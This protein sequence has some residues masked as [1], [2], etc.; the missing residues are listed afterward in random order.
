[1][2]DEKEDGEMATEDDRPGV[3]LERM[4]L[5]LKSQ[6]LSAAGIDFLK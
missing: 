1:M 2:D 5:V 3:L 6:D 4:Y